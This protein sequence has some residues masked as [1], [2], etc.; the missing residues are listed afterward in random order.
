MVNF[1]KRSYAILILPANINPT[2]RLLK[3][4]F[5]FFPLCLLIS[6][7]GNDDLSG[8]ALI[9][10]YLVDAPGDFDQAWIAIEG[11]EISLANDSG[12][13]TESWIP[14]DYIPTQDRVNVS[15]LIAGSALIL[16]RTEL[17]TGTISKI[18]LKWGQDHFVVKNEENII[19]EME[20]PTLE[21]TVIDVSFPLEGSL[22]Y[23]LYLDFDLDASIKAMPEGESYKL[24]PKITSFSSNNMAAISG[25]ISPVAAQPV[26][27]A[28]L[29][30]DTI[31]TFTN[32]QGNYLFRGLQ[33][34]N[35]NL[36]IAPRPPYQ[37]S[38]VSNVPTTLG[39][40]TQIETITLKE[41]PEE[42][43]E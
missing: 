25:R 16:G 3:N 35:Y 9:N 43:V 7:I 18:K 15:N 21:E 2:M 27:Y 33:E 32:S 10:I 22:S 11:V 30:T 28:I 34:G 29:G 36:Y 1:D 13:G 42:E 5:F 14:L 6:C 38:L 39:M 17:D 24:Q 20:D 8:K 23:D 26:L 4:L 31:S 37:D 41:I 40:N 12:T 19:L